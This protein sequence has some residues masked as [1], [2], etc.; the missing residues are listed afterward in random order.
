M[1]DVPSA[2]PGDPTAGPAAPPAAGPDDRPV[3]V[4]LATRDRPELLRGALAAVGGSL[5]PGDQVV[6]VDSASRDPRVG[7]VALAAGA[8]VVRCDRP[9]TCRARN[10]GMRASTTEL[11]AFLD[12]DC[13]PRPGWIAGL[14]AALCRP[15]HPGFVTGRVLPGGEAPGR[16]QLALSVLEAE[17]AAEFGP[18]DDPAVMGHGANMAWRRD[19]LE[20][21]GGFDEALGPGAPLRA[22]EDHDAFWRALR[23]GCTGWFEPSAVVEHRQWRTRRAQ[24]EAYYGYGVGSGAVA[25]KRWRL[26]GPDGSARALGAAAALRLGTRHLVWEQGVLPA[27]RN[28]VRGYEMGVL[29]ELVKTAG[30]VRGEARARRMGL[31]DGHFVDRHQRRPGPS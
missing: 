1:P 2:P 21:I 5:R 15:P 9:G 6:V 13:L 24:L 25:V 29:A 8:T 23:A 26:G 20:S 14:V 22:A 17:T 27:A 10:A 31:V 19:A 7:E 30:S 11:L 4:V 28:L 3:T 12:D 16:A 18:E